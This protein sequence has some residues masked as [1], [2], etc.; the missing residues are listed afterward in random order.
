M[1]GIAG[2]LTQGPFPADE[3]TA[4]AEAMATA[5][6]HRGPDDSGVWTDASAGVALAFRRLAILDLSPMGHQPMPSASG[7]YVIAFNGEI[8]NYRELKTELA[9]QGHVFRGGS[10]TEVILALCE[11]GGVERAWPRLW[12]MFAIALWDREARVL[13]LTRDRLGK[14]PLYFGWQG[15]TLLFGSELKALRAHPACGRG[16]DRTSFLQYVRFGYVSGA[17]SIYTGIGKVAP[18]GVVRITADGRTSRTQY[19]D[20]S[21]AV[22]A[23]LSRRQVSADADAIDELDALLRDAVARRMVADVPLGAFLSGGV[24]S[25]VIVA[26]MQAQSSRPVQTFSIGF[27][28]E[29]FDEAK[30]AKAVAS[31][32]GTDHTELYVRPDRCLEVIPQLAD[33]YDEPFADVSQIPTFLVCAMARQHVTVSLSGDG[34]DELFGG[35]LRYRWASEIWKRT[36]WWPRAVRR[37][38]AR[39]LNALAPETWDA[40]F[41]KVQPLLPRAARQRQPGDKLHK[42][43]SVLAVDSEDQLYLGLASIWKQPRVAVPGEG[44]DSGADLLTPLQGIPSFAE[45]MMYRDL[46]GYLPDDILVKVDRASMGT[47]LEVRAPLLDHRL[48]EWSWTLPL[49]LRQR[50]GVGKWVLRRVLDRYVPRPLIDR[51]KSGFSVPI[52]AWLRG[53]LRDWAEVLLAPARLQAQGLFDAAAIQGVWRE[54]LQGHRNHQ[55]LLWVVLMYQEWADRW[56]PS[57]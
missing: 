18:G 16:L 14:K 28:E 22:Q 52:H 53:P 13:Y 34:G 45:R 27:D 17:R 57:T 56:Q 4:H 26:L 6:A 20:P 12:G 15:R 47:S 54:H 49:S 37:A 2:F 5:I 7:R 42:L 50:D 51:P 9:A 39:G 30:A 11:Q 31:H 35:Y 36:G 48:V 40:L 19:W 44:D 10:D 33:L 32:L 8:Y 29:G 55:Y 24:D 21:T 46:V 38:G 23:S 41:G 1:C 25:S 43:A 3:G